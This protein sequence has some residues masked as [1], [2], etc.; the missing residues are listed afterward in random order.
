[1]DELW[2]IQTNDDVLIKLFNK[3]MKKNNKKKE[4]ILI[5]W[6]YWNQSNQI[7]DANQKG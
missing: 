7:W 3:E 4:K 2:N 1:V 6:H 5:K